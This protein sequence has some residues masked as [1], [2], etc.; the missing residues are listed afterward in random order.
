MNLKKDTLQKLDDTSSTEATIVHF[1]EQNA[2]HF[3]VASI[4]KDY[5]F[6]HHDAY[7]IPEFW[8][9]NKSASTT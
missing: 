1:I 5:N 9:S 4:L 7:V 8:I 6:G 2:A 3:I